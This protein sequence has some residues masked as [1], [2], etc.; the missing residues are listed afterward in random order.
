MNCV[1]Q[2]LLKNNFLRG[3]LNLLGI[4][5]FCG[6]IKKKCKSKPKD[7]SKLM[8]Y[9]NRSIAFFELRQQSHHNRPFSSVSSTS[10][11][12]K[13]VS[14]IPLIGENEHDIPLDDLNLQPQWIKLTDIDSKLRVI[15]NN[16]ERLGQLHSRHLSR[17]DD[18]GED[19]REV[20]VLTR[21]ISSDISKTHNLI[22]TLGLRKTLTPEEIKVKK[23]IQ[24]AKSNQLQTLS[25]EFKKKQRTYLNAIQRNAN[26][27][28]WGNEVNDEEDDDDENQVFTL[29]KQ[30]EEAFNEMEFEVQKRDAE[31]RQIVRSMEELSSIINDISILVIKQGTL[32]DQIEYNL[33]S[34]E[35]SMTVATV[36]LKKADEYHRSYRTRLC[37]L[38]ILIILVV[39]MVFVSIIKAF[40]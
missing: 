24:S 31:I 27:F 5:F 21:E 18:S 4:N 30:Q 32:M 2:E 29:T 33:E 15:S 14:K 39:T 17:F 40:I 16:I 11:T 35:E 7:L 34:T 23:N 28:G 25:L 3:Y 8:S 13:D 36:E 20:E 1:D 10:T 6:C 19:E 9:R 37:I 22:K 12:K 38:L 26:S